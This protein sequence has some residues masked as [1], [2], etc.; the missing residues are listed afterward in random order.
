MAKR[1]AIAR[2]VVTKPEIIVYDE[3]TTGLDPV[4]ARIVDGLIQQ[5]R[6]RYAVTSLVITHDM[7][8]AC[9]VAD[10]V[11]FLAHG[12]A[13]A[14]GSPAELFLSHNAEIESYTASSGIDPARLQGHAPASARRAP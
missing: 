5:M 3:P 2:A 9:D 11:V 1:V 6:D 13:V 10:R 14:Q 12:R 8:T 4:N 7:V